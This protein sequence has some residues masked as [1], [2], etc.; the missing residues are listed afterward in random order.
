MAG[1]HSPARTYKII[2]CKAQN[3]A[4]RDNENV[5]KPQQSKHQPS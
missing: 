5:N 2:S 1:K 4:K 3:V